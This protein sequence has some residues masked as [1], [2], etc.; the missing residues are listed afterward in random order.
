MRTLAS[1]LSLAVAVALVAAC[2]SGSRARPSRQVATP[3]APSSTWSPGPSEPTTRWT[4]PESNTSKWA[5]SHP[6]GWSPAPTPPPA[7]PSPSPSGGGGAAGCGSG[8]AC[9]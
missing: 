3:V 6:P 7:A 2:S 4:T 1:F 5:P 9:G 8:G